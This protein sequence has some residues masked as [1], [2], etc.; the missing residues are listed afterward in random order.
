MS[1]QHEGLL[2]GQHTDYP[3]QYDAGLLCPIDRILSV[4][5][6][7]G[8]DQWTAYELSWL[9][10][11]GKPQVAIADFVFASDS[12]AIIESK[13][14][15]LYLNSLNQ[16]NFDSKEAVEAC[17]RKDLSEA[18]GGDVEIKLYLPE[19]WAALK[20]SDLPGICL[21]EMDIS[22]DKYTIDK[23]FLIQNKDCDDRG[24]Y[25]SHM[26]RSLCPVTGQPD[27]ASIAI[28]FKGASICPEGL[29][30]YLISYRQHQDFHEQCVE[31]IYSDLMEQFDLEFF[32]GLCPLCKAGWT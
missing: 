20:V 25:H 21:D 23:T 17:L 16:T 30:K 1:D 11:K 15:K 32:D 22:A 8:F 13:S 6:V 14:F 5:Q 28:K 24:E 19:A 3:D 27:W 2:L 31:R 10:N 9:D 26:L 4:R 18:S 29:L 12:K 7:Y